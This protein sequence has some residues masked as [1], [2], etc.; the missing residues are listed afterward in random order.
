MKRVKQGRQRE[1]H[2]T[3]RLRLLLQTKTEAPGLSEIYDIFQNHCFS[4]QKRFV[5]DKH[6]I[7]LSKSCFKRDL[8]EPK[9]KPCAIN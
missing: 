4:L 2:Q 1:D 8:T 9:M 3:A 5:L 7:P 6:E